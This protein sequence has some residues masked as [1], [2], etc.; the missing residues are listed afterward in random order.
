MGLQVAPQPDENKYYMGGGGSD[1]PL[2]IPP[3]QSN[4][5]QAKSLGRIRAIWVLAVI[6]ALGL[7]VA[8]GAGP[9]VG[10][11]KSTISRSP[12]LSL[13]VSLPSAFSNTNFFSLPSHVS[14]A[15][16]E[17]SSAMPVTIRQP[18]NAPIS[19]LQP[20][21]TPI[22]T[23]GVISVVSNPLRQSSPSTSTP[24]PP[25][26][27]S[28]TTTTPP[29]PSQ[30]S[31]NDKRSFLCSILNGTTCQI[32][33]SQYN[34]TYL[35]KSR[36]SYIL[37]SGVNSVANTLFSSADNGCAAVFSCHSDAEYTVG[38]TSALV[39]A[40]FDFLYQ[41]DHINVCGSSYLSNGC[42]V[43]VNACENCEPSV[44]CGSLSAENIAIKYPC[45]T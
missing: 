7:A 16:T 26:P 21:K 14:T 22:T 4:R 43:T 44:P 23:N 1:H 33:Y 3:D 27:I 11:H 15:S 37:P 29:N 39:K 10:L 28:T 17:A 2:F 20:S 6:T 30:T 45:V 5:S 40:A 24:T 13:L 25:L 8:V 42:H 31:S 36:A 34:D 12:H 19:S 35:Y 18:S 41:N 32:A 38:M 9:G